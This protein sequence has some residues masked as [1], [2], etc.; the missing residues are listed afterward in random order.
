MFDIVKLK[1]KKILSNTLIYSL[2]KSHGLIKRWFKPLKKFEQNENNLLFDEDFYLENYPDVRASGMKALQ[3]YLLYGRYEGRKYNKKQDCMCFPTGHYYSPI[4]NLDEIRQ[5]E[6]E[7]WVDPG[8]VVMSAIDLNIN[9]QK[10]LIEKFSI[11]YKE[12]PFPDRKDN[13]YRYFYQNPAFSYSDAIILYSVIRY[14]EPSNIIEVGSG[15]SSALI[16]DSLDLLSRPDV[17]VTFIEPYNEKLL[18]LISENDKKRVLILKDKLEYISLDFFNQLDMNDILFIDSTHIVKTGSDVNC[19]LLSILPNLKKGVFIHFHDI[20]FPFEYPK[21]W[22]YEGRSWNEAYFLR[23]FL[24]FNKSFK[25]LL[26]SDF[27]HKLHPECFSQMP[28]CY[29]NTGGSLWLCKVD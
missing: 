25:I 24:M 10:S 3:H 26:F 19:L 23:S 12:I 6:H 18:S 17:N 16:L 29:K 1:L 5:R 4:V 13:T 20:F 2:L 28:N 7:I 9:Y 15:Y 27:L 14:F 22:V 11:F 21:E 8:F